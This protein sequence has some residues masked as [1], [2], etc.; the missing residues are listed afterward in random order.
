MDDEYRTVIAQPIS[1]EIKIKGSKF[2]GHIF[3]VINKDQAESVY[4]NIRRKYHDATHNCFAYRISPDEFR[5][6]DDGEPSGTAGKPIL[7]ILENNDLSQTI[8]IVTRY[9]GGTKLGTGGLSRA[10]SESAKEVL[11]KTKIETKTRYITINV[12]TTYDHLSLLLEFV[13]K[14]NGIVGKTEY[15]DKIIF[16][17]QIPTTKLGRFKEDIGAFFGR[18]MEILESDI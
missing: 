15:S 10:Y 1:Y 12:E 17:L 16:C 3:H 4:A 5:H 11:E 18:G 7:Q 14:Y 8:I 9:F 6:S 2:I 13:N